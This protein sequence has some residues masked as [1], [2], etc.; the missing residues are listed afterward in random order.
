LFSIEQ[1]KILPYAIVILLG[2]VG[3][4]LPLPLLPEMFLD[5]ERSLLPPSYSLGKKTFLLGLLLACYPFGQLLG[6]P[7]LG[8]LS[9]KRG[10]KKTIFFSLFICMLAYFYIAYAISINYMQGIFLG[11]FICGFA[12]G[13]VSIAQ[14]VIADIVAKEDKA[15]HFGFITIFTCMGFIIG[16]LIGGML[17]DQNYISWFTFSTPFLM[18]AIL[19]ALGMLIIL[20][21]SKETRGHAHK[22]HLP[23]WNAF[24]RLFIHS[25]LRK[26]YFAN[27]LIA[28]G[29][30]SFFRFLPIYLERMFNFSSSQLAY[31]MAYDAFWIAISIIFVVP[32]TA[33]YIT[34]QKS[35]AYSSLFYA[36]C[37]IILLIPNTPWA[38]IGTIPPLGLCFAF[39]NTYG[40]LIISNAA[41]HDM[42]GQAMGCL[43]SIQVFAGVLIGILG[44]WLAMDVPSL[45]LLV[46]A[47]MSGA[48]G[49]MLFKS[50][51]AI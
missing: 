4:S 47:I 14:S 15:R 40:S 44:G 25:E 50:H 33:K 21:T 12:E 3:F 42:H 6:S 20:V 31:V 45:P 22:T 32:L 28:L 36:F 26:Y 39:S 37:L 7:I 11:L 19:T 5:P 1:R 46:G 27:F 2:F 49:L 10:R 41:D 9:D 18:G 34:P 24:Q 38:L 35:T 8:R 43:Q 29:F 17:A 16:P 13:N 30:Y 48:C 51:K 23:F